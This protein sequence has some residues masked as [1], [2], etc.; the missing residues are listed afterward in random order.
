[1]SALSWCTS[2]MAVNVRTRSAALC[3]SVRLDITSTGADA[4]VSVRNSACYPP[5]SAVRHR[6]EAQLKL[7]TNGTV[8]ILELSQLCHFSPI[9]MSFLLLLIQTV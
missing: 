6:G 7:S 4:C 9:I 8:L 1:M 3:A 5:A 2:V